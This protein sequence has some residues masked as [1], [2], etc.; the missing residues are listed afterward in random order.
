[1]RFQSVG[2]SACARSAHDG[3]G[4]QFEFL[5]NVFLFEGINL[6]DGLVTGTKEVW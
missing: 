3:D 2:L 4:L 6:F 5:P 1:M